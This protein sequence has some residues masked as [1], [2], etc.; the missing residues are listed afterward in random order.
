MA[1]AS[2]EKQIVLRKEGHPQA[3]TGK[4]EESPARLRR[5]PKWQRRFLRSLAR[6]PNVALAAKRAGVS[7]T[8]VYRVREQDPA[9]AGAWKNSIESALDELEG[10]AFALAKR[11]DSQLISWL[12]RCHRPSVYRETQRTEHA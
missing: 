9:F 1:K 10:A 2:N 8:H 11:G 7:R 6:S 4:G 5:A 12:L 3:A